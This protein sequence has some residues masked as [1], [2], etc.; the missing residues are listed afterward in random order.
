MFQTLL[1]PEER[2]T[3]KMNSDTFSGFDRK[4]AFLLILFLSVAGVMGRMLPHEPNATP[5]VALGLVAGAALG[6]RFALIVPI[7]ALVVT[8]LFLGTYEPLVMVSVYVCLALPVLL[9]S[10]LLRR[11]RPVVVGASALF[12]SLTFFVVTNLAVWAAG[13]WY[14]RSAVGLSE[15]FA[16]ALPF[17]RNMIAADLVWSAA[18]F[19]GLAV[20]ERTLAVPSSERSMIVEPAAD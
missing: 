1:T 19:A 11:R 7:G 8:D 10:S 4:S 3:I 15:C 17:A 13:D 2:P 9:G 6:R 5:T 12:C 18:L 16:A 14:D 20:L